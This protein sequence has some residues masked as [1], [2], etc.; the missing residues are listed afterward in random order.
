MHDLAARRS[1]LSFLWLSV[2]LN[3]A[4]ADIL[5]LFT[6]GV[7]G[8]VM[9]GVIEGVALSERLMLVAA[10]FIE[11]PVA[12]I[13]AMQVMPRRAW[14]PVNSAAAVVTALFVLGGGSLKPHYVFF[15]TCEI[16]A[17]CAIVW[18]VWRSPAAEPER[19]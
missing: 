11:V 17:L 3:I 19:M 4:F 7:L 18:L 6:P 12:M 1:A 8:Q 2:A 10:V 16:L 5:G 15:A 14:R 13:V 9:D